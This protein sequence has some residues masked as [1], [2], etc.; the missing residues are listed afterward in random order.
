MFTGLIQAIGTVVA[1]NR[2]PVGVRLEI[3][4]GSWDHQPTLG[5]SIAVSGCCLT[6]AEAEARR[7]GQRVLAFDVVPETLA[8]ATLGGWRPGSRVNLERSLRA[9]D[10]IGGHFVQGH[11]EGVGRVE[12]IQQDPEWRVRILPPVETADAI[13]PKGSIAVDGV[14]LTVAA[15]KGP[16]E[17]SPSHAWFDVALIPTTLRLTTL[18]LLREGDPVNIETDMMARSVLHYLRHKAPTPMASVA[19]PSEPGR[20]T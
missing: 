14:S 10:L 6:L 1:I 4:P 13:V 3:D 18:A 7:G 20:S 17:P 8:K 19:K 2:T 5:E 16:A 15:C 11:I 12:R 9:S